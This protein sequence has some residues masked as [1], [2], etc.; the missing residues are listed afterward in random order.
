MPLN[1]I[2][3]WLAAL[4]RDP[5]AAVADLFAGRCD[6]GQFSR[7]DDAEFLARALAEP[8][9]DP[10]SRDRVDQGLSH[11]LAACQAAD[12]AL[13]HS[14]GVQ[15]HLYRLNEALA[16]I[17]LL[18]LPRSAHQ[19]RDMH[20]AY[21][22][23]LSQY[24]YGYGD[25]P[26]AGYWRALA[27][28][29]VDRRFQNQWHEFVVRADERFPSYA[30]H[31]GLTGLRGLDLPSDQRLL[32]LLNALLRRAWRI[33]TEA[34]VAEFAKR[35][36][37][38]AADMPMANDGWRGRVLRLLESIEVEER[39][40]QHSLTR[41]QAFQQLLTQALKPWIGDIG[42]G[43]AT[44]LSIRVPDLPT[45]EE[46]LHIAQEL[47]ASRP[48]AIEHALDLFERHRTYAESSG[49]A[50]FF[51]RTL[52]NLG[53][54]VLQQPAVEGRTLDDL[55]TL[56][57]HALVWEPI[58][59][60]PWSLWAE[61]EQAG[62]REDV[63]EAVLWEAVRRFPEN[64]PSRVELALLL[65]RRHEG[66]RTPALLAEAEQLLREAVDANPDH[67]PSRGE[68]A[69]LLQRRH[70]RE[71]T[72]ELLAEAEQLLRKVVEKQPRDPHAR[73]ALA[74]LLARNGRAPE[75]RELLDQGLAGREDPVW[76]RMMESIDQGK[77]LPLP[78]LKVKSFKSARAGA[79]HP[80]EEELQ[81]LQANAAAARFA[82]AL[83]RGEAGD[84]AELSSSADL[85]RFYCG[86]FG[87]EPPVVGQDGV[88]PPYGLAALAALADP[89]HWRRLERDYPANARDTLLLKRYAGVALSEE[90]LAELKAW[91]ELA[92]A[93][94]APELE[95]DQPDESDEGSPRTTGKSDSYDQFL[96]RRLRAT[97]FLAASTT[98][99]PATADR[100]GDIDR[101][102]EK[103][104]ARS[105]DAD[106]APIPLAA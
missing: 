102:I 61:L 31:I 40:H 94:R 56:L 79:N 32:R 28:S 45:F 1:P 58:N 77:H 9:A 42:L 75:G 72:P 90:E 51:V 49:D 71:Q 21:R 50:F 15:A 83:E 35:L 65:Q 100:S 62:G 36:G 19:L 3:A 91:L 73:G 76:R 33:G 6:R 103:H 87:L 68:L 98:G 23:W 29:Q 97:G 89:A 37:A 70:E 95:A 82:Y 7:L 57:W 44:A 27:A 16:A 93:A 22:R 63:A 53:H 106:I 64:E 105:I 8:G 52:C 20:F 14:I 12:A 25:G 18:D 60:Y 5:D 78:A 85:A 2:P 43:R 96:R 48:I 41:L 54:R 24:D 84:S 26:Y 59:P 47:H 99:A 92:G 30:L 11:W 67:A 55:R 88:R 10:A 104:L 13:R 66:E 69:L 4:E 39:A 86:W 38:V 74:R 81:H 80:P 17:V 101:L 46:R 34:A